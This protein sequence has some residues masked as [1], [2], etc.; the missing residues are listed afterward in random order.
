VS[1]PRDGSR[2]V[3]IRHAETEWSLSG[4]HTGRSDIPLT[5]RGRSVAL[6]L[7]AR[8]AELDFERV[9]CSP[10]KRA[11]ETCEL[12]GFGALAEPHPD[13]LEWDYGEYEGLTSAEIRRQRPDWNLWREGCPGGESPA[14]VGVRAD[15]VI[16]ELSVAAGTTAIFSH[17]HMLRVLGARWIGLEVARGSSLGLATGAICLLAHERETPILSRWNDTGSGPFAAEDATGAR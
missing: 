1:A 15:R 12:S 7:R 5:E 14:E 4:R 6:E 10:S 16:A 3:L 11:R 17:G 9:L 8:L 13:L 2:A